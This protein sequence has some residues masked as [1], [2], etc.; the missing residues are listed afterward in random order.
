MFWNLQ[1]FLSIFYSKAY[2]VRSLFLLFKTL[3]KGI[4]VSLQNQVQ[5]NNSWVDANI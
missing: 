5:S 1:D 3:V 2:N 4:K